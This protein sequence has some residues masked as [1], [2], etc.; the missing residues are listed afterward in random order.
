MVTRPCG[1]TLTSSMADLAQSPPEKDLSRS[2]EHSRKSDLFVVAGSSLDVTPAADMPGEALHAGAQLVNINAG[3]TPF[4]PYAHIRFW[5]K[6][7][8]VLHPAV[9]RLKILMGVE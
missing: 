1:A 4:D 8:E 6:I 9:Q 5:E 3:D 2:C 7:G